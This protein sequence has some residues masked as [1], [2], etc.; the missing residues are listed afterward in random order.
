MNM[1]KY[2]L[3]WTV[4]TILLVT[5]AYADPLTLEWVTNKEIVSYKV[6]DHISFKIRLRKDGAIVT[7][8]KMKWKRSGSDQL[9]AFGEGVSGEMPLTIETSMDMPGFVH[10]E[11]SVYNKD[12]KPEKYTKGYHKGR[13]LKFEGGVGIQ[14]EK[15]E[16]YPA[17]KDFDA[18]WQKQRARLESV[19]IKAKLIPIKN[20]KKGFVLYDVTIDCAGPKPVRG[21]FSIPEKAKETSLKAQVLFHGYRVTG[22]SKRYAKGKITLDINPYGIENGRE[23]EYYERLKKGELKGYGFN[24]AENALPETCGFNGMILRVMRALDYVKT[25]P[26]WNGKDLIVSGGS[27]GGLQ[28]IAAAALDP[29]VTGCYAFKPWCCDLGGIKLGRIRGWR[30][31]FEPG[32]AYY[33]TATMGKRVTCK[34]F[35]STGMGDYVCPP[36]GIAVLYNNIKGYKTIQYIQGATHGYTPP[37][38]VK[39][40]ISTK[41]NI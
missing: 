12:G 14:P 41:K 6:G 17:P 13:P 18:F 9:T 32:L 5:G 23:P 34:T 38:P 7:G 11:V 27:Q 31:D 4:A 35:I 20:A 22:A 21:Y 3:I 24:R 30:P 25:R 10:I 19:P 16:G 29:D 8:K 26:E 39:Q 28:S 36:S 2:M 40:V 15:L 37:H 33:D 1:F